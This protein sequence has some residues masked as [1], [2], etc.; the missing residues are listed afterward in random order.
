MAEMGGASITPTAP[1]LTLAA[2]CGRRG[3]HCKCGRDV[4]KRPQDQHKQVGGR[5]VTCRGNLS[6]VRESVFDA[7]DVRAPADVLSALLS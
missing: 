6:A 3:V 1:E 2:R 7:A 4:H 5:W